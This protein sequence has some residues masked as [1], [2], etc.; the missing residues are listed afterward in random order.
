[1]ARVGPRVT[2]FSTTT[3]AY[4]NAPEWHELAWPEILDVLS[5]HEYGPPDG[6]LLQPLFS[7]ARFSGGKKREHV[8]ELHFGVLD[9]DDVTPEALNAALTKASPYASLAFTTWSH[10]EAST[11]GLCRARLVVPFDRTVTVQEW[12]SVHAALVH[13]FGGSADPKCKDPTRMYFVPSL[14]HGAEAFAWCWRS[15]GTDPWP[16][17][18]IA[19]R[20]G[21]VTIVTPPATDPADLNALTKL[22]KKFAGKEDPWHRRWGNLLV[23][24]LDGWA[25]AEPGNRDSVLYE[26]AGVIAREFP[27]MRPDAVA[28]LFG[29]AISNMR[30][31]HPDGAPSVESFADK[32]RRQQDPIR[33]EHE[34]KKLAKAAGTY[35]WQDRLFHNND[36]I[37]GTPANVQ[38]ILRHDP[39]WT[40]LLAFDELAQEP[41]FLGA[42]PL[43]H[44]RAGAVSDND[45]DK[46]CVE[47]QGWLQNAYQFAPPV[48][49]VATAVIAACR[50]RLINPVADYLGG[51]EWDGTERIHDWLVRYGGAED[52]TI[53][54]T[55]GAKWLISAVARG[56]EPGCQVD[57]CLILKGRT[58]TKKTSLFRI[59]FGQWFATLGD[60]LADKDARQNLRGLWGTE[61]GELDS[62]R[63]TTINTA[64]R[65]LSEN[66]D[67]YRA[68]YDRGPK[69]RPRRNVFC[70]TTNEDAPLADVT[71]DR[72]F[73]PV[74]IT[75]VDADAVT[76]ARDQIWA[77]A[78]VWYRAG[79]QWWLD[80]DEEKLAEAVQEANRQESD[81]LGPVLEL[82]ASKDSVTTEQAIREMGFTV[83]DQARIHG[84]KIKVANALRDAGWILDPTARH[85]PRP[86]VR[87]PRAAPKVSAG[88]N[89]VPIR[90]AP[91]ALV[92]PIQG[93]VRN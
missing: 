33:A 10:P 78:V 92:E 37:A 31:Q 80:E 26:I 75:R 13:E 44:L 18:A 28:Y 16:V 76:H 57:T 71:G 50:D 49:A 32:I 58:G 19:P 9:L 85:R 59:L 4:D 35:E 86:Y 21:A 41:V 53:N 46:T 56:F 66:S 8:Q 43:E 73:W 89:V 64:K 38:L 52:T 22:A 62:L 61:L 23:R 29:R 77:E 1:V 81:F 27:A 68:S 48:P 54:R 40:G 83:A 11:K 88:P 6:K 36:G 79:V 70:G 12:P 65:Y 82:V 90:P 87:G 91:P 24:G 51:L 2:G 72:R 34:A 45:W 60:D 20:P 93:T 47:I 15:P 3:N 17:H 67:Y 5:V 84:L 7:P 63:R 30:E 14:P 39:A 74:D 55:F 42:P 69:R 25:I